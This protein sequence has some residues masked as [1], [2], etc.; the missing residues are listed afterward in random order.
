MAV[1][2]LACHELGKNKLN[3]FKFLENS[4]I[5]GKVKK[6]YVNSAYGLYF[7]GHV[8]RGCFSQGGSPQETGEKQDVYG[9]D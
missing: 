6:P 1:N 7:G 8:W 9:T 3:K 2:Y 5:C 4:H